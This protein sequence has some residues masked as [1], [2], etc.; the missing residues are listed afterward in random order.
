[1]RESRP[2]RGGGNTGVDVLEQPH[3][4]SRSGSPGNDGMTQTA[5][6]I[7]GALG[8]EVLDI[9]R[10][11]GWR[12]DVLAVPALDH[13]YPE[14]IGPDVEKRILEL[15]SKYER[16]V[17]VFG[18]CGSRGALDSVLAHHGVER[19]DGPHCY[20]MYGGDAFQASLDEELG[21]FFLTDFL[22]RGFHTIIA[23]S[24]GLDRYPELKDTYFRNYRRLVYLAQNPTG[25]LVS[26]A[27]EAAA[28]LEMPLVVKE[29]GYGMLE[30]RLVA[31][32]AKPA[33]PHANGAEPIAQQLDVRPLTRRPRPNKRS[34]RQKKEER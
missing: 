10:R 12:A 2:L 27:R 11:Q 33:A 29:T 9:V 20:E 23:K 31:L 3:P 28:Y 25:E 4:R 8:R 30:Q 15:R 32:M 1:M 34:R 19:I 26:L 22:V 6:I 18:D 17:V 5:F 16:L 14:R 13:V 24:M 7:C 21:S